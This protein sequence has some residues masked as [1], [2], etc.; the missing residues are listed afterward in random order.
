MISESPMNVGGERV[1]L[2]N[3]CLI[4]CS[5]LEAS[6]APVISDCG[7]ENADFPSIFEELK[8]RLN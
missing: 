2:N 7:A 1:T 5:I 8:I 3:S 4:F 6:K